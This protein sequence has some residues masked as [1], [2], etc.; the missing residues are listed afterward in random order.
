[1]AFEVFKT[2][3]TLIFPT[4]Q[5]AMQHM[6]YA[7]WKNVCMYDITVLALLSLQHIRHME[8]CLKGYSLILASSFYVINK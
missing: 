4:T 6:M 7:H 3:S 8:W 1:M 2:S 5:E